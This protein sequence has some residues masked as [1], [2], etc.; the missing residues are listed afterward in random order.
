MRDVVV[1]GAPASR[2]GAWSARG[3][4]SRMEPVRSSILGLLYRFGLFGVRR[5]HRALPESVSYSTGTAPAGRYPGAADVAEWPRLSAIAV[6]ADGDRY[7]NPERPVR[8][9][10]LPAH[11]ADAELAR[12]MKEMFLRRDRARL[13]GSCG[14]TKAESASKDSR[15]WR[16]HGPVHHVCKKKKTIAWSAWLRPAYR[17]ISMP[18]PGG[19]VSFHIASAQAP[20]DPS[21]G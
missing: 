1:G 13:C 2:R 18:I 16:C 4:S 9:C 15:H 10:L 7:R 12:A 8:E 6:S 14:K 20:R 3:L 5:S 21:G 19:V 11:S 17:R